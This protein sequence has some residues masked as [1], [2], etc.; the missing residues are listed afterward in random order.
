M[1]FSSMEAKNTL[2]GC[3]EVKFGNLKVPQPKQFFILHMPADISQ[4]LIKKIYFIT[5]LLGIALGNY[6]KYNFH[7]TVTPCKTEILANK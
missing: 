5:S 7:W 2:T 1:I 3:P 4:G 6:P